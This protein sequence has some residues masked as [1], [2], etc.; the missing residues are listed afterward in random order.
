MLRALFF[1]IAAFTACWLVHLIAWRIH[2]P[3]G[4]LLWLPAIFVALPL[5]ALSALALGGVLP[6]E[7][8]HSPEHWLAPA[9]LHLL[10]SAC[11]TCSYAGLTE[12]SPSAEILKVVRDHMPEGI[13]IDNLHV[14]SFT[15]HSLTGKRLDDLVISGI[16]DIREGRVWLTA[17]GHRAN[18]MCRNYRKLTGVSE[19]G[20]G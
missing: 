1:G 17:A 2:R 14:K 4:Y 20:A 5:L 11:Y 13:A 19:C 8:L 9:M 6:R 12:Y 15:E 18:G 7:V 10:I 16:I 3:Q